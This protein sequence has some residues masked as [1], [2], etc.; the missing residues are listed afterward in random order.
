LRRQQMSRMEN[1]I[2]WRVEIPCEGTDRR[3]TVLVFVGGYLP[4]YKYGGPIQS[5]S[6]IVEA[7]GNRVRF[8][9]V[10]SDRDLGDKQGYCEVPH[11]ASWIRVGCAEVAYLD[12]T[13]SLHNWIR[14]VRTIMQNA[15][16]DTIY[17]NSFFSFQFSIIPTWLVRVSLRHPVRLVIAPRGEF[18][19]GA[20]GIK[21]VKKRAFLL[22]ARLTRLYSHVTWHATGS[23]E[24]ADIRREMGKN[25][26]VQIAHPIVLVSAEPG[27]AG[28]NALAKDHGPLR[29]VFFSRISPKKN[30][31]YALDVM[32]RSGIA[33][34]FDIIGPI[35]D[36]TYW[37]QCQS[38][39]AALPSRIVVKYLG[40]LSHDEALRHLCTYHVMLFPTLGENY[41]HV[42]EEALS[43]GLAVVTTDRTPWKGLE[44]ARVGWSLSLNDMESF[45]AA[46]QQLAAGYYGSW[47]GLRER[48]KNYLALRDDGD[49]LADNFEIL[50]GLGDH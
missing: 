41:G 30:L 13:C 8:L 9:V 2:A 38:R 3:P 25:S 5:V 42:I 18:S 45:V 33:A 22:F 46:M 10:T 50:T 4:G 37:Q 44:A 12:G 26:D 11:D 17:L 14:K 48:A 1:A 43:A 20:L 40:G 21:K 39:I 7:L 16:I 34:S 29:V 23:I 36:K 31:L 28:R 27:E 47:N 24:A 15:Q 19:V 49:I 35:E 6:S 32:G